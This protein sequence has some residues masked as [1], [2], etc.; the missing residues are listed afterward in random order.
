MKKLLLAVAIAV[1]AGGAIAWP[2]PGTP[3]P[4]FYAQDTAW[5]THS[6]YELYGKVVLLNFWQSG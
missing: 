4:D 1:L 6:L 5:Q 3:A 2:G